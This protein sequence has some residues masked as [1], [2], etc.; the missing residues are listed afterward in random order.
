MRNMQYSKHR[1]AN[2]W[3]ELGLMGDTLSYTD[4]EVLTSQALG[5]VKHTV[6]KANPMDIAVL[7]SIVSMGENVEVTAKDLVND[8]TRLASLFESGRIVRGVLDRKKVVCDGVHIKRES[9]EYGRQRRVGYINSIIGVLDRHEIDYRDYLDVICGWEVEGGYSS[10]SS[11]S[12]KSRKKEFETFC[13][14]SVE[15]NW[16]SYYFTT[17]KGTSKIKSKYGEISWYGLCTRD[18]ESMCTIH[19]GEAKRNA[20]VMMPDLQIL[21]PSNI[22]VGWT[23]D[24]LQKR[25]VLDGSIEYNKMFT[26]TYTKH[27]DD[28]TVIKQIN[29]AVNRMKKRGVVCQTT[30]GRGRKFKW[31]DSVWR[32]VQDKRT[33]IMA[34]NSKKRK[35]GDEVNG[36]VYSKGHVQKSFGMEI[37]SYVWKPI[38]KLHTYDIIGYN[39]RFLNEQDAID[40]CSAVNN[41]M[42]PNNLQVCV[43]RKIK[44]GELQFVTPTIRYK[45]NNVTTELNLHP[46]VEVESMSTPQQCLVNLQTKGD[47][48]FEMH[49]DKFT[50]MPFGYRED[51]LNR[52]KEVTG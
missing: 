27:A 22:P 35:L 41:A 50:T 8:H 16:P 38:E 47:M 33:K 39:V 49:K 14:N 25:L 12:Q 45:T 17:S 23:S 5:Y 18:K 2:T 44:N 34:S 7:Y 19:G 20:W 21:S 48:W 28:K 36:W 42:R 26:R 24:Y 46:N 3:H 1:D 15:Y 4:E 37:V 9:N 13:R 6:G 52:T 32:K 10:I 40:Y 31:Y 29:K 30:E 51:K 43:D 11:E